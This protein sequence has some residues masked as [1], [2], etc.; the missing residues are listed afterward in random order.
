MTHPP[1]SSSTAMR[2]DALTSH[3]ALPVSPP[4]LA[5]GA[6]VSRDGRQGIG[7]ALVAGRQAFGNADVL[8][9]LHLP[10]V[11]V[12]GEKCRGGSATPCPKHTLTRTP[13]TRLQPLLIREKVRPSLTHREGTRTS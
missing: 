5:S 3:P 4:I 13:Q 2:L 12:L 9:T 10:A 1:A 6:H 11:D 8:C 7:A